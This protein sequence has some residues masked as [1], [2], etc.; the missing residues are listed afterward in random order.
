MPDDEIAS[1]LPA[2]IAA[3]NL[4]GDET[5]RCRSCA[6]SSAKLPAAR[7]WCGH[8]SATD[9]PIAAARAR[10]VLPQWMQSRVQVLDD[11]DT[12]ACSASPS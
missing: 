4:D 9:D 11:I 6:R 7:L 2:R 1:A 5:R 12:R 10:L 8:G 3:L